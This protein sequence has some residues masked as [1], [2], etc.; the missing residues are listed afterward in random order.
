MKLTY[1][2]YT[3]RVKICQ[4]NYIFLK[5]KQI[6]NYS[7]ICIVKESDIV[8]STILEVYKALVGIMV[9]YTRCAMCKFTPASGK[10]SLNFSMRDNTHP[11]VVIAIGDVVT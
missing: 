7:L 1:L 9:R 6:H 5:Q 10:R 11:E 3:I 8:K 4:N 2:F